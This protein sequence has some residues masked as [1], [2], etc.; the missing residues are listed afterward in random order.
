ME[1]KGIEIYKWALISVGWFSFFWWDPLRFL[2]W[3]LEWKPYVFWELDNF[4]NHLP[5]DFLPSENLLFE[6]LKG[7]H[8]EVE[9]DNFPGY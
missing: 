1:H 2:V 6:N 9:G 8:M 3:F 5:V 7:Y 4:Y